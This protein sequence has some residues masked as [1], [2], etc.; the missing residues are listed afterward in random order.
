MLEVI[1]ELNNRDDVRIILQLPISNSDQ[2]EEL[3][4]SIRED[5]D[6][7]RF[8]VRRFSSGYTNG[9]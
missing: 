7:D 6:V 2:T 3:L 4:E 8:C 9:Y 5:K 1:Q